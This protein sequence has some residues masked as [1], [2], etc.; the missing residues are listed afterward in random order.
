MPTRVGDHRAAGV[1]GDRRAG[2]INRDQD[3]RP[4][5]RPGDGNVVGCRCRRRP[6]C[7]PPASR[8]AG[9]RAYAF[10]PRLAGE[11]PL[12]EMPRDPADSA[13]P[14]RRRCMSPSMALGVVVSRGSPGAASLSAVSIGRAVSARRPSC[15]HRRSRP[16]VHR[17]WPASGCPPCCRSASPPP[18]RCP[19]PTCRGPDMILGDRRI[20]NEVLV[21]K[22]DAAI[23][24]FLA[25][26]DARQDER[27]SEEFEGA[28]EREALVAAVAGAAAA[29]RVEHRHAQAAAV[30]AFESASAEPA[31][32][33]KAGSVSREAANIVRRA[34]EAG[35]VFS[36]LGRRLLPTRIWRGVGMSKAPA[37]IEFTSDST[38]SAPMR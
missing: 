25:A 16:P 17:N 8:T 1:V 29:R 36:V 13:S 4:P 19:P 20:G 12:R 37:P 21:G 18:R 34:I 35:M 24:L 28:A 11:Q 9:R 31:S 26:I 27:G 6:S 30:A 7:R 10:R 38:T 22:N 14:T 5:R 3:R 15:A 32:L 2:E 23:E 33:A